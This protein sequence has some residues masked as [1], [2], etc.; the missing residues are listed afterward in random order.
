MAF[1]NQTS[2]YP[3]K[4]LFVETGGCIVKPQQQSTNISRF[5][6]YSLISKML[7]GIS[8]FLHVHIVC[9]FGRV[10][11]LMYLSWATTISPERIKAPSIIF[12]SIHN[13]GTCTS[14]TLA[15][16]YRTVFRV[17]F[18]VFR[19]IIFDTSKRGM[20]M[21]SNSRVKNAPLFIN[22]SLIFRRIWK[23]VLSSRKA[24]F[25]L[26]FELEAASLSFIARRLSTCLYRRII[27]PMSY[28]PIL[29]L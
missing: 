18:L 22:F 20:I 4:K 1:A 3:P 6:F 23:I 16:F 13:F 14:R 2:I 8:K 17:V 26:H 7:T 15:R 29:H 9:L 27:R 25:F 24:F 21:A 12:I 19:F 10:R 11:L 5:C 28:W